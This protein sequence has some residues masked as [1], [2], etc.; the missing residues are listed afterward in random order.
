MLSTRITFPA[1]S[2]NR[3]IAPVRTSVS[4]T[5]SQERGED[6]GLISG[7]PELER[8]E[9]ATSEVGSAVTEGLRCGPLAFSHAAPATTIAIAAHHTRQLGLIR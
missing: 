1:K 9:L 6:D 5:V 7:D 8:P 2:S 3:N 4:P